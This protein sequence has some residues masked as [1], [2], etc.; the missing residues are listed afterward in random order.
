MAGPSTTINI[1]DQEDFDLNYHLDSYSGELDGAD[2]PLLCLSGNS[3]Y[4]DAHDLKIGKELTEHKHNFFALHLNIQSLSA[5]FD[6]L[7]LLLSELQ[8]QFIEP[9]FILLC[10]TFLHDGNTHLFGLPGYNF[11]YKNR[12]NMR[13]GG[14]CMY[15][16]DSIQFNLRDDLATF[17]EGKFES[18][19]IETVNTVRKTIVGEIY[20]IPNS[21]SALSLERYDT[22]LSK[23]SNNENVIIGSDLNFDF[24]KT[25]THIPTTNLLNSIFTN[26]FIPT[27]TKPTRIT[28]NSATLIDNI[29]VKSNNNTRVYSGIISTNISDHFP[30]FCSITHKGTKLKSRE[31]LTFTHRKFTP[32]T[33]QRISSAIELMNWEYLN[34]MDVNEGF[35][36]F[37]DKLNTITDLYAPLKQVRIPHKF[38]IRDPWMTRG[39]LTSSRT[40]TKLFHKCVRKI[41]T[42]ETYKNYIRY[43][44]IY[45]K[46]KNIAKKNHYFQIFDKFKNDIKNT[47]KTINS[48]I[49][50]TNDKTSIPQAFTING[51]KTTNSKEIADNFCSYFTNIGPKYANEIPKP[52]NNSSYHLHNNRSRNPHSFFMTPSDPNEIYEVLKLLKPKKSAGHDNLSTYFLKLINEKVATPLSILIN[53]SLQTGVFPDS[54]KI[55]KVVPIYKSK[56]KDNFSNYRPISLLPSVSKILEKIVHKRLYFFLELNDLL[57]D[58]QFGF[59]RKHS[60]IDAAAKFITDTCTALDENKATLAVYLDLSKA[61]DTIDHSILLKKLNFYG[62][63][64]QALDWF[65]SYLYNRKQ[66]V[67]YKGSDSHVET[68]KCGVPQGSVLGPL[69]FIIYT[70]D[71]PGCLNLTK[72]VLFADDTTVYLSSKNITYLYT[73][74][75]IELLNLTDWFRA[76]KL[77]LNISKTNYMLF[78]YQKKQDNNIDLQLSNCNMQ[79]INCVKFLGLYI[80]DKLKWDEHI[81]M[82]KKKISKSFFAINKVKNIMPKRHL[83]I[84][85][86]S[87]IYPYLTYGI[88]LWGA[89]CRVHLSKLIIMQKKSVRIITGAHYRA[90]TAPIFK[91]LHF[92]KLVDLYQLQINKYVLSF[93]KGLLPSSLRHIFTLSQNQHGHNIRH[94]TAYK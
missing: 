91:H 90:H 74:M 80:D 18:I 56:D 24:L 52:T 93:I 31:S 65:S 5:K 35:K 11:I 38:I 15:I 3:L 1:I 21:N 42:D 84:L 41:R 64:G 67:H 26:S 44:N 92:L 51:E 53:K 63:R 82:M 17:E 22:I 23:L 33:V 59:R 94:S 68:I 78:T 39:L 45:N 30:V 8:K 13:R 20:R 34:D 47:W 10:E 54:L 29:L 28:H 61:F 73:T 37:T 55:A 14:V 72:S 16:K 79:R 58:N 71:L 12:I 60:T 7:K 66:F 9:D 4:H 88:I 46:L 57:Y 6:E 50:K 70:N 32:E 75:N 76:N 89:A 19:F 43:R 86:Y 77:S 87:L 62:I 49:G 81:N 36:D 69:L 48:I 25:D 27:I 40:C 2:N 83:S 85:Y